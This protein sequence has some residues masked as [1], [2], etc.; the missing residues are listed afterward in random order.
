MNQQQINSWVALMQ[1][2]NI[3]VQAHIVNV[4]GASPQQAPQ[5]LP[6]EVER[7]KENGGD[8]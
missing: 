7:V 5:P 2:F 6:P 1:A 4:E 8:I 3:L